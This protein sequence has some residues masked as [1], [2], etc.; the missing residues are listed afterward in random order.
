VNDGEDDVR[1]DMRSSEEGAEESMERS[2]EV[3][4]SAAPQGDGVPDE[5]SVTAGLAPT[6]EELQ[7]QLDEQ[8][9]RYL[10]LAAEYDNYRKRSTRE[11]QEAGS[12]AQAE[13]VRQ[14]IDALDDLARVA[15]VE[16]ASTETASV[17]Q[18]VELVERKLLK[19]LGAAGLELIHPVDQTFNP[20]L[21]E[22]VATVPAL[23]RE[24]DHT[25]AQVY[26]PGYL[27]K[28]QLLRPARVV[29]KQWNG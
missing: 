1:D 28:G 27:F 9:D 2:D 10:R 16:P 11:R 25:V 6:E 24:D 18:G 13:L 14:L 19:S 22:A 23:S 3:A 29:V 21:H 26:Q 12:R 15:H 4:A 20:E 8:R 5:N 17:V 7:R